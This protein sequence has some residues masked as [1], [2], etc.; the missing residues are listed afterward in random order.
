[1]GILQRLSL[2]YAT[3]IL[4]H[5]S[6]GYGSKYGRKLASFFMF[7][8]YCSYL[9]AMVSFD[10]AE[11]LGSQ[12]SWHNNMSDKCNFAGWVDHLVLTDAHCWKGGYTDP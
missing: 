8:L 6:T 1:M 10:G 12:C 9:A 11:H 4:V 5:I 3:T 2:C 7:G